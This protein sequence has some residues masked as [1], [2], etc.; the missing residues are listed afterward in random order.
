MLLLSSLSLKSIEPNGARMRNV[1][2]W[3]G[4]RDEALQKD[5][6]DLLFE[7]E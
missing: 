3:V 7:S 5:R 2:L 4:K 1:V 6:C